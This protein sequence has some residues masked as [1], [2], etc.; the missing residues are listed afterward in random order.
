MYFSKA[1][2]QLEH[3]LDISVLG[4]KMNKL[5]CVA[6]EEAKDLQLPLTRVAFRGV[7]NIFRNQV[8]ASG[9]KKQGCL[10]L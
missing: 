1:H 9:P 3:V 5:P 7:L 10:S 2:I 4:S 6:P 8:V